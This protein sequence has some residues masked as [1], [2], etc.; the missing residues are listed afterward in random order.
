M[1][2]TLLNL[3]AILFYLFYFLFKLSG[4]GNTQW[5]GGKERTYS[6]SSFILKVQ[7]YV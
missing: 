3:V 6:F 2:G 1:S 5:Y 4:K 7:E